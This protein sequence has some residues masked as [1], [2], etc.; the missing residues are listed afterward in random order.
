MRNLGGNYDD[1]IIF[2][3]LRGRITRVKQAGVEDSRIKTVC[4][5]ESPVVR[6]IRYDTPGS[7]GSSIPSLRKDDVQ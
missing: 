6:R 4:S 3:D 2:R 5:I 7:G 1:R